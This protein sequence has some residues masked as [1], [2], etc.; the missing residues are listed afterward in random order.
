MLYFF[1]RDGEGVG[2]PLAQ[3]NHSTAFNLCIVCIDRPI[4]DAR[5]THPLVVQFLLS[6]TKLRQ[7]N[8]S[9]SGCQEFCPQVGGRGQ[10]H[11][12]IHH[13]PWAGIPPGQTPPRLT[14]PGR[15]PPGRRLLQRTVRILM[16]CILVFIFM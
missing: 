8:I 2:L 10:V 4:W 5:D 9:R 12:W 13:T 14:P 16:E 15:H 3:W 1:Y 11:A 6:A 7:R